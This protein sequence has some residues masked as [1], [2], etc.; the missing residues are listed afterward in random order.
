MSKPKTKLSDLPAGH[1]FTPSNDDA[2]SADGLAADV[3][4]GADAIAAF[5]GLTARQVYNLSQQDAIPVFRMGA[6]LCARKSTWISWIEQQEQT[7][8][9]KG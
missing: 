5:S 3:L 7:A 9:K 4:L 8:M 2:P 1:S 6:T